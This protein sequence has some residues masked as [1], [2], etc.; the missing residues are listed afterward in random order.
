MPLESVCLSVGFLVSLSFSLSVGLFVS[1]SHCQSVSLSVSLC[2]S[3][4]VG[5][6]VNQSRQSTDQSRKGEEPPCNA[7]F[8]PAILQVRGR[9]ADC[10]KKY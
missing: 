2:L 5:L 6:S 1:L 8:P 10:P 7:S 3:L 9:L 4:A